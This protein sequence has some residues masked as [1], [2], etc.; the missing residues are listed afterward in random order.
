[1]VELFGGEFVAPANRNYIYRFPLREELHLRD[2]TPIRIQFGQHEVDGS[3]VSV[4]EGVIAIALE[5]NLGPRIPHARLIAD[6]SFLIER[7]R[8]RLQQVQSGEGRFNMNAAL[9]VIGASPC[10]NRGKNSYVPSGVTTDLDG[11]PRI[12]DG[13]AD[14]TAT[15]DLGAYEYQ[16]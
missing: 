7:L 12:V 4:G 11:Y 14:G 15:V 10:I 1:M 5:E 16:P 3:I 9:R 13:N 8:D 6:D 2:D